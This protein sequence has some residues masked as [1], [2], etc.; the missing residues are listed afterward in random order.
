[1]PFLK[2]D[3]S[4]QGRAS[5]STQLDLLSLIS[6][7]FLSNDL[8]PVDDS[9]LRAVEYS[10]LHR[11]GH[12]LAARLCGS[13]I[14]TSFGS[15]MLSLFP[16]AFDPVQSH[17]PVLLQ[18]CIGILVLVDLLQ[19]LHIVIWYKIDQDVIDDARI[20]KSKAR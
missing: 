5:Q 4:F 2:Q 3:D 16:L 17:F 10:V 14:F 7:L 15:D 11:N 19:L 13:E 9:S 1:M 18:H 6:I 12:F 20:R 8:G